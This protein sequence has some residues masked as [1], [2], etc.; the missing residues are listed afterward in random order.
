MTE[1][2]YELRLEPEGFQ[3]IPV[4]PDQLAVRGVEGVHGGDQIVTILPDSLVHGEDQERSHKNIQPTIFLSPDESQTLVTSGVQFIENHK[5]EAA[6]ENH[7]NENLLIQY[8]ETWFQDFLLNLKENG[9]SMMDFPVFCCDGIF[10]SNRLIVASLGNFLTDFLLEDSCIILPDFLQSEFK[11]FHDYLFSK[12]GVPHSDMVDI[13]KIG[14]VFGFQFFTG[15]QYEGPR[16]EVSYQEIFKNQQEE[17]FKKVY[18]HT[19]LANFVIKV[20]DKPKKPNMSVLLNDFLFMDKENANMITCEECGRRFDDEKLL[21]SHTDT[22]HKKFE[23]PL[24]KPFPC[25]FCPKTFSYLIN[26]RRHIFLVHPSVKDK[27][28]DEAVPFTFETTNGNEEDEEASHDYNKSNDIESPQKPDFPE[29]E[30]F[31]CKICGEFLKSKR[32]LVAHIQSHYGGGY[33]CDYPGC[34]SVF[35][36]NAKLNRHKLV[37]TGVKA[38]KCQYCNQTF[39]LRHNLKMHEKTHTRT[40]LQKC[41][42]C[43]YETIQKSNMRL[44]EAT[45]A[46]SPGKVKGR[47]AGRQSKSITKAV[48]SQES[49]DTSNHERQV[50]SQETP[51]EIEQFIA[52]M[53]KDQAM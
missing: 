37:H 23:K 41:R 4:G 12:N 25:K 43:A 13:A 14:S 40:D 21:K 19:E 45:H 38:F 31:K 49:M 53:E 7:E 46:K 10:W 33:K 30:K 26:V 36:E 29:L 15:L 47:P 22:V 8:G 52:E 27:T 51:D 28:V 3:I 9:D 17:Y 50:S 1:E 16:S 18:G 2:T 44:H 24:L 11:S 32:Y 5:I 39:S 35:R 20:A 48:T 34:T 42:F 6:E